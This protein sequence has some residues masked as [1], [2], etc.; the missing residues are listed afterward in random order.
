MAIPGIVY[1]VGGIAAACLVRGAATTDKGR[2]SEV[3]DRAH[4]AAVRLVA[5]GMHAADVVSSATQTIADEAADINVE[6]RRKARIDAAVK[7]RMD[8]LEQGVRAEVIAEIDGEA[9]EE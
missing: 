3:S 6:A 7:E 8:E 9:E 4:G 5:A 1:A 2:G